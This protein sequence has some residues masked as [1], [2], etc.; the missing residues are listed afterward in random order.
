MS[1]KTLACAAAITLAL[2]AWADATGIMI[3]DAYAR[4]SMKMSR[5]GAAFMTIMNHT[6][7]N[8]RLIEARS[9]IADRVELHTHVTTGDGVMKMQEVEDGLPIPAGGMHALARGGDHVMFL[10]LRKPLE[11]GDRIPLT[12]V[13]EKAGE[14]QIEVPVDLNR[15]PGMAMQHNHGQMQNMD[16]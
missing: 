16:N 5:T 9:D 14:V 12:L 3:Q 6:D 7:Q 1:L 11:Q 13:F 8:D 2:P 10:G 15:K 4:A